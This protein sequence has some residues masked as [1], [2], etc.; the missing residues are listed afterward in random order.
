MNTILTTYILNINSIY[1]KF[2]KKELKICLQFEA[3]FLYLLLS[4]FVYTKTK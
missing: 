4:F 2:M 1:E 3:L